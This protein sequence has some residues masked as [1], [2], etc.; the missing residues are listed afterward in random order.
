VL[1]SPED[2][3]STLHGENDPLSN[4]SREKSIIVFGQAASVYRARFPDHVTV[5][6]ERFDIRPAS[7]GMAALRYW[8]DIAATLEASRDKRVDIRYFRPISAKTIAERQA[9]S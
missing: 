6:P 1:V 7:V 3:A 4:S 2:I 5:Q 9:V 8:N